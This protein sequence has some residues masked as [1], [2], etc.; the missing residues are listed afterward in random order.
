[1]KKSTRVLIGIGIFIL[2]LFVLWYFSEIVA[3]ILISALLSLVGRP[4][5]HGI[6]K[7]RIGKFKVPRSM[8]TAISMVVLIGAITIIILV[9]T[10]MITRE[11]RMMEN[12]NVDS[13][14]AHFK[15][16]TDQ[17]ESFMLKYGLLS[18]GVS[19]ESF[20][21]QELN[22]LIQL[23]SFEDI[24]SNIVN[25]TGSL[26]IGIF[27]V[28]FISFFLWK[29]EQLI[30]N[31]LSPFFKKEQHSEIEIILN[32][33]RRLLTRYFLGLLLEIFSMMILISVGL[34]LLGI[35]NALL[36]G[37]LAGMMNIIPY[38]G[39]VIGAGLGLFL[40]LSGALGAGVYTG[41]ITL[42]LSILIIFSICKVLDDIFLQPVI[43]S[44]SVKAHP[45]EIFLVIMMAGT[46]AG[47]PGMILAIPAYTVIRVIAREFF[48]NH[49]IVKKL[50]ENM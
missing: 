24:V 35:R 40:G 6:E 13:I 16:E 42:S 19:L 9:F 3:Y 39:P 27:S 14:A 31:V 50:T 41:L 10:P 23:V 29:D 5:I 26:F 17:A 38:I 25:F 44:S 48:G 11:V 30:F 21:N 2:V 7:I 1:M 37:I 34:S 28:L 18:P 20:V 36:I 22:K 33:S 8:S 45:L 46:L 12:I 43:Y 47:I 15:T 32:E 4:L 49:V